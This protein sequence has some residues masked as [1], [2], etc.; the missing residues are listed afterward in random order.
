MGHMTEGQHVGKIT[1]TAL[2]TTKNGTAQIVISLINEAGDYATARLFFS[3]RALPHTKRQLAA[4]GFVGIDVA[5][6]HDSD[7]LVGNKVEFRVEP[8]TY[9]GTTRLKVGM[10]FPVGGSNEITGKMTA[11]E[12]LEFGETM[13]GRM[14]GG[15]GDGGHDLSD[16]P[17]APDPVMP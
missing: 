10:L 9:D 7:L 1:A 16:I 5:A 4:C 2:A 11:D 8:D 15:E 3:D 12:A 6:L 17:F 13:K 14:G